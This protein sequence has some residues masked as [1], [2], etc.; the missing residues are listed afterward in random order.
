MLL[1]PLSV[2]FY[3]GKR[4]ALVG[5]TFALMNDPDSDDEMLYSAENKAKE[6]NEAVLFKSMFPDCTAEELAAFRMHYR[7]N[8]RFPRLSSE[9]AE[10]APRSDTRRVREQQAVMD[11][12]QYTVTKLLQ[13]KTGP[14]KTLPVVVVKYE[15]ELQFI[16]VP[17]G[18]HLMRNCTLN[19]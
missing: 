12:Q 2:Q 8:N 9:P 4:R 18:T 14:K 13:N 19:L 11:W 1:M 5:S 10:S 6:T 15:G 16:T 3:Q 7:E 17:N